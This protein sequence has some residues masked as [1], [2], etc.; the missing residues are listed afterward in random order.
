MKK[1]FFSFFAMAA[2]LLTSS[3]SNDTEDVQ[4][5][6][7][8]KS[9]SFQVQLPTGINDKAQ[10]S[11]YADGTTATT[12]SYKVFEVDGD[13]NTPVT[14][15]NGQTTI[16]STAIVQ[17]SLITGKT[18]NIVF[19]A[20][21][22]AAP[23]TLSDDGTVTVDYSAIKSNDE[24]LDAFYRCYTYKAGS[25]VEN[26][27]K[28]YRPFAQLNVGTKDSV[29][30]FTAGF[31]IANAET[32]VTVSGIANTLNLLTGEVSGSE[33][34]T[35][36]MNAIPSG[37]TFPKAGYDY[38]SMNYLLV[39]K[40]AKSTVDVAWKITDQGSN[41]IERTFANTPVQGNYRT[42]IYG[43]LL[44][45]TTDFNVEI[46]PDFTTPD[47]DAFVEVNS[48]EDLKAAVAAG[49]SVILSDNV[50]LTE[51]L[52][53][54]NSATINL[55][56]KTITT[57]PN[58]I[59]VETGG[60]VT[61]SDGTIK[62]GSGSKNSLQVTDGGSLTLDNVV[63]DAPERG[64]GVYVKKSTLVI[65]NSKVN[66][67]YFGIGANASYTNNTPTITIENCEIHSQTAVLFNVPGTITVKKSNLY[68]YWQGL[69][70][71]GGTANV[72]GS[73]IYQAY[74]KTKD[75]GGAKGNNREPEV[76]VQQYAEESWGQGNE[77]PMA[78]IVLG[79]TDTNAYQYPT[80]L[81]IKDTKV[82]AN[83]PFSALV[84]KEAGLNTVTINKSGTVTG[85]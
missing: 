42:N 79:T 43:N 31:A 6:T 7:T 27:V 8:S 5:G 11:V 65:K 4:T 38:L 40:D 74:D 60:V 14:A 26:P 18:Y 63:V 52:K 59:S 12:L 72:E 69:I 50:T 32:E 22:A 2:L 30:A 78:A 80:V 23:Y 49:N 66:T 16:N 9:V 25:D 70:V 35:Y 56:G 21:N 61:I 47:Y 3:C 58:V 39:G 34:V 76:A 1:L 82:V 44:T 36:K 28:L 53:I 24:S 15:L 33:S 83:A 71:R 37:Q 19:W 51:N 67:Q 57:T 68:G 48:E 73:E 45:S 64:T 62:S 17:L 77:I 41:T 85:I 81:N 84:Q 55:N 20:A 10:K 13:V 46:S 75:V 29:A 54:Q